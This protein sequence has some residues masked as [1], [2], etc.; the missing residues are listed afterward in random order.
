MDVC[1]VEFPLLFLAFLTFNH[2]TQPVISY[3]LCLM[4]AC[5]PLGYQSIEVLRVNVTAEKI[6]RRLAP[7]RGEWLA[8]VFTRIDYAVSM[9]Y[10]E[11]CPLSS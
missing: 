3:D 2:N 6:L 10:F 9:T 5:P 7:S 8:T 1:V 4:R 11:E